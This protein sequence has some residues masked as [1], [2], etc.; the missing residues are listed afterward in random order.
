MKINIKDV[1]IE[2]YINYKSIKNIYFRVD[3]KNNLIV[4]APLR[5][6]ETEVNALIKKNEEEILNLYNLQKQ[7][8]EYNEKFYYLGKEYEVKV[9]E[10]LPKVGF[11]DNTVYTPSVSS[12]E[13]FWNEECVKV[14]TGEANICK[15]CFVNLPEFKIKVRKMKTRWGVCHTRKKEITLNTEL[16]KKDIELI[17]YVII[18]ELCHFFEGNH[19]KEFW[20]LVKT[21]CPKYKE[22]KKRLKLWS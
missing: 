13:K 8:N 5:M 10:N 22:Y 18:H 21:A 11:K 1:V 6:K 9:V 4:S 7:K 14:F 12:L 17:D 2:T 19:G 16:L 20:E 15:K 3:E